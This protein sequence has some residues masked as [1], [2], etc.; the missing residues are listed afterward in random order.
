MNKLKII[1]KSS[2]ILYILEWEN[3]RNRSDISNAK[4]VDDYSSVRF[5]PPLL[6]KIALHPLPYADVIYSPAL[7]IS[8]SLNVTG[9]LE[10][11]KAILLTFQS[12]VF[13][14]E[15]D[16]KYT[17]ESYSV[18]TDNGGMIR[19]DGR[20][21]RLFDF[22]TSSMNKSFKQ[23]SFDYKCLYG[24]DDCSYPQ[25]VYQITLT[26]LTIAKRTSE[27][28]ISYLKCRPNTCF[29]SSLDYTITAYP[30]RYKYWNTFPHTAPDKSTEIWKM[31]IATTNYP[32][33]E[34]VYIIFEPPDAHFSYYMIIIKK[35][36]WTQKKNLH[37]KKMHFQVSSTRS[38]QSSD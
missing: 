36:N 16:K 29:T 24:L 9:E 11:T 2:Y 1:F 30:I 37:C 34:D 25:K 32:T 10:E 20:I 38:I 23:I 21:Y 31:T 26:S 15:A 5:K 35:G 13:T 22:S 33:P 18:Q 3:F 6:T 4:V 19:F 27:L 14:N 17:D 8:F 7:Y 28:S 12:P